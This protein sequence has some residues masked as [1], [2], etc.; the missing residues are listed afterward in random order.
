MS[1][2]RQS[3]KPDSDEPLP[4]FRPKGS[5]WDLPIPLI[6]TFGPFLILQLAPTPSWAMT[7]AF[8]RP[9]LLVISFG[10]MVAR[11]AR[12]FLAV[13]RARREAGWR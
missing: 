9:G 12:E 13:R 5:L 3:A 6:F 7:A 8:L 10:V 4:E 1:T 2:Y 11:A